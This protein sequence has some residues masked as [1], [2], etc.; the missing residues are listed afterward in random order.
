MESER[1]LP[2]SLATFIVMLLGFKVQLLLPPEDFWSEKGVRMSI[3]ISPQVFS[4]TNTS[5]C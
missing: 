3:G 1:G 5:C 4:K 2:Y